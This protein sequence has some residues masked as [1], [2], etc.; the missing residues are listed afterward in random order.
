MT[1]A[2]HSLCPHILLLKRP[3]SVYVRQTSR[4]NRKGQGTAT[5]DSAYRPTVYPQALQL[6]IEVFTAPLNDYHKHNLYL[7]ANKKPQKR[8]KFVAHVTVFESAFS[9][10]VMLDMGTGADA[11]LSMQSFM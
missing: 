10:T 2:L 6:G 1:C 7:K 11:T 3:Q 5:R 9:S 8:Q 4:L